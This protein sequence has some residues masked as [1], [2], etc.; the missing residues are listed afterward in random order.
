MITMKQKI[1][2]N[3]LAVSITL[4]IIYSL[5]NC[6]VSWHA[7]NFSGSTACDSPTNSWLYC[8]PERYIGQ[9]IMWTVISIALI[10]TGALLTRFQLK[11]KG[12]N[13]K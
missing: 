8:D 13:K 12:L 1:L 11:Q 6:V 9:S 7:Y 10:A 4:A 3:I 5:L 2:L